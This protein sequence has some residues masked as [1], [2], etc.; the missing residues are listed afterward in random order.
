M[1][2]IKLE[3]DPTTGDLVLPI[4]DEL[5]QEVGWKIGDTIRW[6]EQENGCWQLSKVNEQLELDFDEKDDAIL[7]LL[8]ENQRLKAEN[9]ELKREHKEI[10]DRF[11]D[12]YK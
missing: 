9:E 5:M 10:L 8:T 2:T 11:E 7:S 4:S 3:T 1:Q 6:T 12:D